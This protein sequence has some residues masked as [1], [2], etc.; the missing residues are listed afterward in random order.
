MTTV[1]A[2][3]RSSR[4][5]ALEAAIQKNMRDFN[6]CWM[7]GSSQIKPGHDKGDESDFFTRSFAGETPSETGLWHKEA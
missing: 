6:E 3:P 4:G 1:M 7:A 5:Q 2:A